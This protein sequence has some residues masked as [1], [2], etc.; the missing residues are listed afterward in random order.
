MSEKSL[1]QDFSEH[2]AA[3]VLG[4][5]KAEVSAAVEAKA[6]LVGF[7]PITFLAFIEALMSMVSKLMEN[8]PQNDAQVRDSVKRP[9][10]RQ[11]VAVRVAV[12]NDCQWYGETGWR[13]RGGVIATSLIELGGQQDDETIDAIVA[14]CRSNSFGVK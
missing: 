4:V 6:G 10:I 1:L 9:N 12:Q 13:R 3:N 5:T 14:D 8:C 7:D 11:R 2:V